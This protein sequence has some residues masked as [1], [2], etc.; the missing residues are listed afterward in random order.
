MMIE[1]M[2]FSL[3]F[4]DFVGKASGTAGWQVLPQPLY[5]YLFRLIQKRSLSLYVCDHLEDLKYDFKSALVVDHEIK[6]K[7]FF[8]KLL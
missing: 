5:P 2:I 4:D 3:T 7:N 1:D 6:K 8:K